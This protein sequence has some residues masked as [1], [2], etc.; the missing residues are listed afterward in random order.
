MNDRPV[1]IILI[2]SIILI[3]LFIRRAKASGTSLL[4]SKVEPEPGKH[5]NLDTVLAGTPLQKLMAF[6]ALNELNITSTTGGKHNKGSLHPKG[7]A[8]DVSS[9]GFTDA[10]V[11]RLRRLAEA[12]GIRLRDERVHPPGQAVWYHP[13]LH[14][15][16]PN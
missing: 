13:H 9:R 10:A 12:V 16:I 2:A 3:A 7:R 11:E 1:T 8:I 15:E 5:D 4:A 6:A 14:L